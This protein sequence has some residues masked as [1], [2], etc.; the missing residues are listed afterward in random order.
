MQWLGLGLLRQ[1]HFSGPSHT[2]R[3]THTGYKYTQLILKSL[4]ESDLCS[5]LPEPQANAHDLT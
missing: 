3:H 1:W 5:L 2:H 4:K